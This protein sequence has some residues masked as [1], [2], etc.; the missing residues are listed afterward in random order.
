MHTEGWRPEGSRWA[1][2]ASDSVLTTGNMSMKADDMKKLNE[3][4]R[5]ATGHPT[6]SLRS[7]V[8]DGQQQAE[9][10]KN[11]VEKQWNF[12]WVSDTEGWAEERSPTRGTQEDDEKNQKD[13]N[14]AAVD[15]ERV[16]DHCATT[17]TTSQTITIIT[18]TTVPLK[19]KVRS[20]PE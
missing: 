9:R 5:A 11:K 8:V 1:K 17:T 19:A 12:D 10:Y 3:D 13:V 2:S 20:S 15:G 16:H 14:E 4:R 6:A 18:T 7:V